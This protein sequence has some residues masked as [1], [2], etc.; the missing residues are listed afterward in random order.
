[1]LDKNKDL[2][3]LH[4]EETVKVTENALQ[5][6]EKHK[7]LKNLYLV[8]LPQLTHFKHK[9][10]FLFFLEHL[11]IKRCAQLQEIIINA[12]ALQELILEGCPQLT[13]IESNSTVLEKICISQCEILQLAALSKIAAE[14]HYVTIL[15]WPEKQA[16]PIFILLKI[17]PVLLA[18]NWPFAGESIIKDLIRLMEPHAALINE[19]TPDDRAEL[20]EL[21]CA[22][23]LA[24]EEDKNIL[25]KA[26]QDKDENVKQAAGNGLNQL[27]MQDEQS[28]EDMWKILRKKETNRK[29]GAVGMAALIIGGSIFF[30]GIGAGI[31]LATYSS[32][33]RP[34]VDEERLTKAIAQLGINDK[35]IIKGLLKSLRSKDVVTRQGAV[36]VISNLAKNKLTE[37]LENVI[38]FM[39]DKKLERAAFSSELNQAGPSEPKKTMQQFMPS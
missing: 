23:F 19:L 27:G 10:S 24:T 38:T 26:C 16:E 12:P 1:L 37:R 15:E 25:V 20:L 21:T 14:T 17:C 18:I 8:N 6:L 31:A 2:F 29:A 39:I 28:I 4:L 13:V 36:D 33:K 34:S 5:G 22:I 3:S 11:I 9:K 7:K 35:E 30:G 32:I